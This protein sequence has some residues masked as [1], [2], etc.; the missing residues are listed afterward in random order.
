MGT[1]CIDSA[2]VEKKRARS[3][4]KFEKFT[5]F[6]ELVCFGRWIRVIAGRWIRERVY[7]T[8]FA[9]KSGII[10]LKFFVKKIEPNQ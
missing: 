2:G 6:A 1:D 8:D 4:W 7:Y 9:N 3:M 5:E 10:R